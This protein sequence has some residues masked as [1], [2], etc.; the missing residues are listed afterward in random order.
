MDECDAQHTLT[1]PEE[2]RVRLCGNQ[3]GTV[4]TRVR[5]RDLSADRQ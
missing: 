2:S 3:G 4:S 1:H 5:I